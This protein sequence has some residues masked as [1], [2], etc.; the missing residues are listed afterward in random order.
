MTSTLVNDR[1][2]RWDTTASTPP[3]TPTPTTWK[4]PEWGVADDRTVP[5]WPVVEDAGSV[6]TLPTRLGRWVLLTAIPDGPGTPPQLRAEL[7]PR[8][9]GRG[10]GDANVPR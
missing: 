10:R 4:R 9:G 1:G 3:A 7:S 8:P 5:R 2:A 6:L